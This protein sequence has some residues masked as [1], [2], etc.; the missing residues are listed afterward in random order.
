MKPMCKLIFFISLFSVT[1]TATAGSGNGLPLV[2]DFR[3]EA[4][5]SRQKQ[6]P[7]LVLFT[8][9]YCPYCETVLEEFL[10]PMQ[11]KPEYQSKVIL[12][13]I[14]I[15][16]KEKLID[17][18]GN[19]IT[20]IAFANQ[21]KVWAV[22]TV[23]LFDSR[24]SELTNITGLLTIDFYLAYLDNAINESQAKIKAHIEK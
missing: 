17:F 11:R 16:S 15:N 23:M 9:N 7:I 4:Q 13:Q 19:I 22:P 1:I 10:M 21:S 3:V 8:S 5:E 18:K 6:A 24:G 12:R 14:D 2:Q 20:S